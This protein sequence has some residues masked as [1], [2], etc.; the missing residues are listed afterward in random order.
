MLSY[1]SSC[2]TAQTP[3]LPHCRHSAAAHGRWLRHRRSPSLAAARAATR[4][5]LPPG[6][7]LRAP[8]SRQDCQTPQTGWHPRHL[9]REAAGAWVSTHNVLCKAGHRVAVAPCAP[10]ATQ[11]GKR[12]GRRG[13]V[14]T[15]RCTLSKR[16]GRWP[17]RTAALA[18]HCLGQLRHALDRLGVRQHFAEMLGAHWVSR[19]TYAFRASAA[20]STASAGCSR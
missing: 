19:E 17:R 12:V 20:P 8:H 9:G 10:C 18:A 16:A 5:A 15:I 4:S 14:G 7:R 13:G 11:R 6:A 1:L 3:R 2:P